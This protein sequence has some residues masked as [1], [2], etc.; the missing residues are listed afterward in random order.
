MTDRSRVATF[1]ALWARSRAGV[2]ANLLPG[3]ALWFVGLVVVLLYYLAPAT[4]TAFDW[5]S[6]LKLQYGYLYS[7]IA[8]AVF[9][10]FIPFLYLWASK[11][12]PS[13]AVR[14]WGLFFVLYWAF[15]GIEVDAFY[16]LQAWLFGDDSGWRTVLTKVAVDQFVY[17]PI[18][19][20]PLTAICYGW[21]D[22]GFS[23]SAFRP[24]MNREFFSFE[25]PSILL[26]IWIV[27]IPATAIIYSLPL[28]L[29]IPLFNLVLCFFVLLISVLSTNRETEKASSKGP[30]EKFD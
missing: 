8:T 10:G 18:W 20:A 17:C 26:S 16:R 27:W 1:H 22:A 14:S 13:G 6:D 21:K 19:S 11:Q 24:K 29:Q 5:V 15:R 7:G 3:A 2:R 23:W 28:T 9:G 25:I 4:R 12:I 30:L